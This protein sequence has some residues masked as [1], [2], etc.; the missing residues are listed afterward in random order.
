MV[1]YDFWLNEIFKDLHRKL[2]VDLSARHDHIVNVFIETFPDWQS[3][4]D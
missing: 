1:L 4:R 3:L 2:V